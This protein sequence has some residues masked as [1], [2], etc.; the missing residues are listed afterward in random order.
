MKKIILTSL[1]FTVFIFGIV[2]IVSSNNP[3]KSVQS[4]KISVQ[5]SQIKPNLKYFSYQGQENIDALT[6]LKQITSLKMDNSGLVTS[7]NGREAQAR[8]KEFWA[9]Y[10]NG[11]MSQVGPAQYITKST[12]KIEWKIE[13]Y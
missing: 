12:D 11:K 4:V 10:I 6:L 7:I 8:N 13:N 9:F 5:P 3:Q 2:M 1:A